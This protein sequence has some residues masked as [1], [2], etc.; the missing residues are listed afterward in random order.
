MFLIL[1]ICQNQT[2]FNVSFTFTF[3]QHKLTLDSFIMQ[4]LNQQLAN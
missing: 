4:T 1:N 2:K 3:Q